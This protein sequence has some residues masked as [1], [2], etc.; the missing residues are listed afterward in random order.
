MSS[1]QGHRINLF[2]KIF[3][4][5]RKK[6]NIL[7]IPLLIPEFP[8][9]KTYRRAKNYIKKSL[10]ISL[11]ETIWTINTKYS[12]ET[13]KFIQ[14]IARRPNQ[15]DPISLKSKL[16]AFKPKV[17]VVFGKT[18]KCLKHGQVAYLA[19]YFDGLLFDT[20]MLSARERFDLTRQYDVAFIPAISLDSSSFQIQKALEGSDGFV[21]LMCSS[22]TGNK[23]AGYPKIRNAI[24]R[25]K[26]YT[27]LPIC[28]GFGIKSA[29]DIRIVK[30]AGADGVIVGTALLQ[31]FKKSSAYWKTLL[32]DM[33]IACDKGE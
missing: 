13:G 25:I 14:Q 27:S 6:G 4:S 26:K 8:D 11:V 31:A 21:Y 12:K 30:K 23:L 5:A 7:L 20:L 17:C 28:C 19:K 2:R 16:K 29:S 18:A 15:L 33:K 24:Q 32:Q 3:R 9:S 10:N 22:A 1:E